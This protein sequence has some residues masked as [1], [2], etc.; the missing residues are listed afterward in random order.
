MPQMEW[1][2]AEQKRDHFHFRVWLDPSKTDASGKPD[3]RYVREYR[4][5]AIPPTGWKTATLNGAAYTDWASYVQ[6]E[7]EI[8]AAADLAALDDA[9]TDTLPI[10]GTTFTPD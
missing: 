7:V 5:H 6:A 3:P 4:W 8:L 1:L 2:R 9:V 10:Q